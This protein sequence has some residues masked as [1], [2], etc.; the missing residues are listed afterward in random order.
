MQAQT[1]RPCASKSIVNN[2]VVF[3]PA[4]LDSER[5][6]PGLSY[7]AG[8]TA[9]AVPFRNY[10][11]REKGHR[12][13]AALLTRFTPN[14]IAQDFFGNF[15]LGFLLCQRSQ[16]DKAT[17]RLGSFFLEHNLAIE[18]GHTRIFRFFL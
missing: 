6:R 2:S 8:G 17:L 18:L 10:V 11:G 1:Q 4:G 5:C 14:L 9:K 16:R 13:P 7:A 3:R 15:G 12:A